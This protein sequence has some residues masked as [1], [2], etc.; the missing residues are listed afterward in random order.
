MSVPRPAADH[1]GNSIRS[2]VPRDVVCDIS[3]RRVHPVPE[4]AHATSDRAILAGI[5]Q[6]RNKNDEAS[7]V[8]MWNIPRPGDCPNGDMDGR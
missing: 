1:N 8:P 5:E 7:S 4:C 6:A 2:G 3:I